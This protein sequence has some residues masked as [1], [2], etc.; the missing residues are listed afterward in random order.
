MSCS[1]F[2]TV[3][4]YSMHVQDAERSS[5]DSLTASAEASDHTDA[6]SLPKTP[7]TPLKQKAAGKSINQI[8]SKLRAM[9]SPPPPDAA[10]A[11]A[12]VIPITPGIRS[13]ASIVR[14]AAPLP[15]LQLRSLA[16]ESTA[17]GKAVNSEAKKLAAASGGDVLK[18]HYQKRSYNLQ[19]VTGG[20]N[21]RKR[22]SNDASLTS[23]AKRAA[24]GRE[25]EEED[26]DVIVVATE[27]R[28]QALPRN[29]DNIYTNRYAMVP[30]KT[31]LPL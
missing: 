31:Q 22:G 26:E 12:S 14:S 20:V 16:A 28:K 3:P 1:M 5:E 25:E 29:Q 10:A 18:H 24:L 27:T 13:V 6:N 8:A 2:A 30:H 11:A 7:Q 4:N 19:S 17:G 15:P 21:P 9:V 23:P